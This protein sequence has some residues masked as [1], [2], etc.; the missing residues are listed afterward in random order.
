MAYEK[1]Y[2]RMRKYIAKTVKNKAVYDLTIMELDTLVSAQKEQGMY[3]ALSLAFLYGRAKG[4]RMAKA[5][6]RT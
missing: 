5:E 3:E 2:E 4:Y 1:D 6:A